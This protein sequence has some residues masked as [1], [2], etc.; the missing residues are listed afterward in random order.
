MQAIRNNVTNELHVRDKLRVLAGDERDRHL[1]KGNLSRLSEP[2][3]FFDR[4]VQNHFAN[5]L[6]H[7][8]IVLR[9]K[10]LV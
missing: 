3:R 6:F 9:Q 8:Q 7:K 5:F 1:T 10:G 4:G 2:Y